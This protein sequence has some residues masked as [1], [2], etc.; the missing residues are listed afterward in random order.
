MNYGARDIRN[1]F[2]DFIVLQ[3]CYMLYGVKGIVFIMFAELLVT[4]FRHV[5]NYGLKFFNQNDMSP[6]KIMLSYPQPPAQFLQ[7]LHM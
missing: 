7:F 4:N 3:K 1:V 2:N 6:S 5:R